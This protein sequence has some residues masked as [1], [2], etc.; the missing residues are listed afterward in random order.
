MRP[1]MIAVAVGQRMMIA[2]SFKISSREVGY[3]DVLVKETDDGGN[4]SA[5]TVWSDEW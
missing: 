3:D 5:Q 2:Q 1:D 4:A